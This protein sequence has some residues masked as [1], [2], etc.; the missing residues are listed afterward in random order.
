MKKFTAIL[1]A[2]VLIL[3]CVVTVACNKVVLVYLHDYDGSNTKNQVYNPD[4]KLPTPEREGYKFDGWYT[5]RDL[6]VPFVDGTQMKSNFHLYAKWTKVQNG[7]EA[8][9]IVITFVYNDGVTDNRTA[10]TKAGLP[11]SSVLA[12]GES[13]PTREGYRFDGWWTSNSGG[14][15]MLSTT[16]LTKSMTVYARWT[17]VGGSDTT[18]TTHTF[19]SYFMYGKC[20]YAGCNVYG[21]NEAAAKYF[22]LSDYTL[23]SQMSVKI[24][25]A[26]V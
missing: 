7:A 4:E 9:D 3:T 16:L 12:T 14:E 10:T 2:L 23:E 15:Q 18:H 11:F 17:S 22:N 24:G 1:L 19:E 20:T 13:N 5:D 8:E 25:R 21:R 6:T 26:H